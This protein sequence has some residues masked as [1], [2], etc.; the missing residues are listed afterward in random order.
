MR[1]ECREALAKA[2]AMVCTSSAAAE[3]NTIVYGIRLSIQTMSVH[4]LFLFT[5]GNSLSR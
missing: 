1:H 3:D 2:L 5:R 4:A